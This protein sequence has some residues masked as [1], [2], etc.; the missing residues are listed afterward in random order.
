MYN[1]HVSPEEARELIKQRMKEAEI[2][3]QQKQLGF[4]D[5]QATRWA[6][7]LIVILVAVMTSLL[8]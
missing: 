8:L 7:L 1:D 6:F 4:S 5:S 3:G 2:Y